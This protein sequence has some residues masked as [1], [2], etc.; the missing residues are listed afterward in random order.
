MP[1]SEHA[2]VRGDAE[3]GSRTVLA[4]SSCMSSQ[5]APPGQTAGSPSLATLLR[6]G[7]VAK[8]GEPA[9]WP[10]GASWLDMQMDMA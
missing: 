4:K 6:A 9:D 10:G 7:C 5:E 1:Q 2:E 8:D 3:L